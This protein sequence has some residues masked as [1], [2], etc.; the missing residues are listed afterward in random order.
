MSASKD[1]LYKDSMHD[2]QVLGRALQR[3][4]RSESFSNVSGFE[5]VAFYILFL[6]A[7][8]SLASIRVLVRNRLV[9]D[10]M[11]LVRV[12]VDKA[13]T[14]EYILLTGA[15]SASDFLDFH[16]FSEW[17]TYEEIKQRNPRLVPKFT[18][19]HIRDLKAFH[20]E[21]KTRIMAD[22]SV[23]NRY[24]RGRDFTELSILKRA[25]KVDA[26]IKE[27]SISSSL[28]AVTMFD[29]IYKKSA[30]Y[31]HP[32]FISIARSIKLLG[33]GQESPTDSQTTREAEILLNEIDP[34]L[35]VEA[36]NAASLVAFQMMTFMA[37]VFKDKKTGSWAYR[38]G[39]NFQRRKSDLN[40]DGS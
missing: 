14:A 34:G 24:G 38:F 5:F 6:R 10:A 27:R 25:E 1:D 29:A 23:K 21:A 33:T 19:E 39:R 17:R 22:G 15:E 7:E 20:D 18:E 4:F 8:R 40:A 16:D 28:S 37:A 3:V 31:L 2:C 13:I 12:M 36:L 26:I 32:S 35:G 30:M 11:A 9:D